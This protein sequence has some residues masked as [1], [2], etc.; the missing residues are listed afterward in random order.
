MSPEAKARLLIDQKLAQA[1]WIVQNRDDLDLTAG[2]GIAVREFPMKSGF[3]FAD[4]LLYVDRKVIGVVEAKPV[5]HTL[6]GV[7]LQSARYSDGL[8]DNLPAYRRPL[9]FAYESTG[10]EIRF[11]NNLDPD[12]RSRDVFHFHKPK[13]L[14]EFVNAPAQLRGRL[15]QLPALDPGAMW[16]AQVEAV[17][18][19]E[20]SLAAARPRALIQMST[21]SGKT[22][23]AANFIY[24]LIKHG[25]ARRVL[26]LVDRSNLGDQTNT[27]FSQFRPPDDGR[28]FSDIYNIQ[29]L[30]T[31]SIDSVSRVCITTVQ[32]L[33]SMLQG[34]PEFDAANEQGSMFD[35]HQPFNAPPVPV[36]YNPNIPIE[37]FDFIVI[38]ECHR[39]IYNLWRQVL[40]YFDGFLIGLTATP[41]KATIGFFNRNLVMEYGHAKAVA[42]GV[43]VNYDVYR[44]NTKI[45]AAGST[46]ES[47]NYVDRR[48]RITRKKRQE[49]LDDDFVYAPNQ[50]DK[51]VVAVD[52][53]RTVIRTFHD[54]LFTEIFPGRTEVPKTLIFAKDDSHAEDIVEI[55]REEFGRG[56]DFCQKITYKTGFIRIKKSQQ[57]ADG[58]TSEIITYEKVSN[59]TPG[60]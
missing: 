51:D 56:N 39:S 5:G 9:A 30:R 12:P 7:E 8:P 43:N 17:T 27:E 35:S 44:I 16:S 55:V 21:G 4:Y 24:R 58:T 14:L 38:D 31:N 11:T 50:L 26:F 28:R 6:T 36:K 32:R 37:T 33:Y 48:D 42:D 13:T 54:K 40:E 59:L 34:E 52:Q 10:E 3:G 23:T 47:G 18:K 49:L 41:A 57:N 22:F 1:G 60:D 15:R 2:F 20:R 25:D 29:L 45:T 46:V 19:L 53:I